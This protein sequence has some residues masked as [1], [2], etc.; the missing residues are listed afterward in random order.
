MCLYTLPWTLLFMWPWILG[1]IYPLNINV[2]VWFDILP[3]ANHNT[4]LIHHKY[5][6]FVYICIYIY[7]LHPTNSILTFTQTSVFLFSFPS[8][9]STIC[10]PTEHSGTDRTCCL[11]LFV[12]MGVRVLQ[13]NWLI[14]PPALDIPT[15]ATR[16]P[17]A[18]RRVPHSSGGSWNLWAE[19]K[20]RSIL[21]K[22]RLPCYI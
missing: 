11:F 2:T 19:N 1:K 3:T 15:L 22:C 4:F 21:P 18:Y 17:R 14:V 7:I 10:D 6:Y 8:T 20:D 16:C 12:S 9:V 13:P 5:L